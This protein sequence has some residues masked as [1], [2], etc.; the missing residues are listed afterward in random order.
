M[1]P[2]TLELETYFWMVSIEVSDLFVSKFQFRNL[3]AFDYRDLHFEGE[4]SHLKCHT[5]MREIQHLKIS[6]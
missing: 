4:C 5:F 6:P 1:T 3:T 2:Q